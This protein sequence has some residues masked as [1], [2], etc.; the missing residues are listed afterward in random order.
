MR[1]A[2][3]DGSGTIDI[4]YLASD[5]VRLYFNQ[6]GNGWSAGRRSFRSRAVDDLSSVQA[7]DLLGNGTA[8]LVW[9]SRCPATRARHA[10]RRP[11]GRSEAVPADLQP[12]QP[13]RRDARPLRAVDDVLP[14]GPGG[15]PPVGDAPPLPRARR[16]AR[17]NVRLDRPQPLRDVLPLSP[18]ATTTA[19][20]ASSAGSA[21]SSNTTRRSSARSNRPAPS[22]HRRTSTPRLTCRPSRTKTWFHTGAYPHGGRV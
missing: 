4:V 21:W 14:E 9:S 3:I 15:R 5:G 8:C 1:L 19:T 17:R 18:R 16:R 7:V 11:D 13:R 10:L 6:A 22:P 2:D 12:Q 20:S